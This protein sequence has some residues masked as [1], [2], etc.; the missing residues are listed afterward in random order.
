MRGKFQA[1]RLRAILLAL[2]LLSMGV[3]AALAFALRADSE[4]NR[5]YVKQAESI[6]RQFIDSLPIYEDFS[7][8]QR[9]AELRSH[10]LAD[11]LKVAALYGI[12]PVESDAQLEQLVAAGKLAEVPNTPDTLYY[13]Y[14]VPRRYR[15]LTPAAKRG[16]ERIA[17]RFQEILQRKGPRPP[18]KFAISSALRP[19]A[20]QERLRNRNANASIVS[21]HSSGISFDLFYDEFYVSLPPP[22]LRPWNREARESLRQRLGYL[23]GA[24]LRRQFHAALMQT[25]LELQAEGGI[26]AIL[27]KRQRCYHVSILGEGGPAAH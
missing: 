10:L 3:C 18:V 6:E 15:Y 2:L 14:N 7:T 11:H 13:Y 1:M 27:E 19:A 16:L 5:A 22:P 8:P 20:Y 26:Y 9:E 25:L 23:I 4:E 21:T 12:P 24:S 17:A